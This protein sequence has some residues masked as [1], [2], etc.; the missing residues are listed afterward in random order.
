MINICIIK[1]ITTPYP[2][3]FEDSAHCLS[4]TLKKIGIA[5]IISYNTIDPTIP[6]IVFGAGAGN[7]V[8]ISKFREIAK[9]HKTILFNMEQ[10]GSTSTFNNKEYHELLSEYTIFDYNQANIEATIKVTR[11]ITPSF[12]FP[13]G[14]YLDLKTNPQTPRSHKINFDLAF[15]GAPNEERKNKIQHLQELG[16]KIKNISRAYGEFLIDAIVD[17]KAVL[18]LHYYDTKIFEAARALRPTAIGIPVISESSILPTTIDWLESGV[19]FI[20]EDFYTS[21]KML[22][23][24]HDRLTE[25]SRKSIFFT[26]EEKWLPIA[27]EVIK[28]S[29]IELKN[30]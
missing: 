9:P 14:P 13:I 29:L 28:K 21:T 20:E 15:Y 1:Q 24:D 12:E 16:L 5:N 26:K 3:I 19:V 18:N 30:F 6:N 11:K 10:I 23:Q 8:P 2:S 7:T 17:C 22:I 4:H 25:L 27:E